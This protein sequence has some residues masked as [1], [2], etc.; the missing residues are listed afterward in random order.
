MKVC[1]KDRNQIF[2]RQH[3]QERTK[4]N[5]W[6]PNTLLWACSFPG[7]KKLREETRDKREEN[8]KKKK[9][10]Q[11]RRD[12]RERRNERE[13]TRRKKQREKQVKTNKEKEGE[14]EKKRKNAVEF[15]PCKKFYS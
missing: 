11:E 9:Q 1:L 10:K 13:E 3:I 4:S 15:L 14:K 12:K 5:L 8:G 7:R 6:V 2:V